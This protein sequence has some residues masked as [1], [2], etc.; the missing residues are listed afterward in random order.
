MLLNEINLAAVT[1]SSNSPLPKAPKVEV[2]EHSRSRDALQERTF[3]K[4]KE[5]TAMLDESKR[6]P[7]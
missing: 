4:L 7:D 3:D 6:T 1:Q 2:T 5:G